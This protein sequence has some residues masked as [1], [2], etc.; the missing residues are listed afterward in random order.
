MPGK[1]KREKAIVFEVDNEVKQDFLDR[2]TKGTKKSYCY[3]LE[4]VDEFEKEIGKNIYDINIEE[5]DEFLLTKFKNKTRRA[6]RS[7]LSALKGYVNFCRTKHLV[8]TNENRF[9]AILDYD[10][11]IN[12][13]AQEN[14]YISKV[15]N[16]ELQQKLTNSTDR[17][18]LELPSWGIRGRTQKGNTHEE[19][20]NLRVKDIDSINKALTI[21]NNDG[22]IKVVYVDDYTIDLIKEV[23]FQEEYICSNGKIIKKN[24]QQ[25]TVPINQTEYVFRTPGKNK[26]G[27]VDQQ[28]FTRRIQ[29]MQK[30]LEEPY[31]TI[32]SLYFSAM[33]DYAKQLKEEKGE[34]T[35]DDYVRVNERFQYGDTQEQQILYWGKTAELV[36]PYI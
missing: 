30:W 1:K 11:Y 6:V 2:Q 34:L 33:I 21:I 27:K 12:V 29:Q 9:D 4:K 18:I 31:L 8:R 35:R 26:F 24:G 28:F 22:E 3:V 20:I 16:R 10:N 25:R 19:L 5:R 32:G 7:T 23:I 14:M 15:K 36:N 17:L 13:Q